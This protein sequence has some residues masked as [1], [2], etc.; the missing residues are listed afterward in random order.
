MTGG[1][2]GR[3]AATR[4]IFSVVHVPFPLL[5]TVRRTRA[6]RNTQLHPPAVVELIVRGVSPIAA[7][8]RMGRRQS[9]RFR[10][11][12]TPAMP[13]CGVSRSSAGSSGSSYDF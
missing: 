10:H 11:L 13:K 2:S 1:L 5:K 8:E 12:R 3:Q 9:P 4:W 7:G 6:W